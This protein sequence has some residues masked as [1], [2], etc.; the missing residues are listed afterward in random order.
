MIAHHVECEDASCATV[1]EVLL[2]NAEPGVPPCP[3]CG[4]RRQRTNGVRR[5]VF[6][7]AV[8]GGT[9]ERVDA[10]CEACDV[11]ETGVEAPVTE[12]RPATPPCEACGGPT[13]IVQLPPAVTWDVAPVVVYRDPETGGYRFPGATESITTRQYD[14]LGLERIEI[15]GWA[16]ARQIER[17]MNDWEYSRALRRAEGAARGRELQESATRSELHRQMKTFSNL[18]RDVAH[19]AIAQGNARPAIRAHE[20]GI[21]I[22]CYSDDRSS[23]D[24]S[25]GADGRRR[26][27]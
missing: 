2:Q 21:R 13:V 15:K 26:R 25:R 8:A 24:E 10:R 6:R 23:R 14:R 22:E 17:K 12:S 20:P 18:G 3:R 27:D 1:T 5:I 4:G 19:A 16:Q 7:S 11:T 9:V